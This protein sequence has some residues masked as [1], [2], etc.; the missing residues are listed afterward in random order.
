MKMS[1]KHIAAM[2]LNGLVVLSAAAAPAA[3]QGLSVIAPTDP[4]W[5]RWLGLETGSEFVLGHGRNRIQIGNF[6]EPRRMR[7][8]VTD[9]I[10]ARVIADGR[11]TI[12]PVS[13]CGE[14]VGSKITV[15][16]A[17]TL[18]GKRRVAGVY[19]IVG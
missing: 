16:P 8:C 18:G 1:S 12:V 17:D 10:G 4:T 5:A 3:A 14:I 2:L 6:Q 11:Q 19:G 7:V 9:N 15:E 13:H